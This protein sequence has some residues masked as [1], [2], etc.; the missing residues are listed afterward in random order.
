MALNFKPATNPPEYNPLQKNLIV[1]WDIFMQGYRTINMDACEL[2][3]VI[4]A[5]Q[6]FWNYFADNLTNMSS[7][8][9]IN[10]MDV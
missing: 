6:Q 8:Q 7:A 1:T 4:P 5:N 9:K 2:I 10:F 3:S